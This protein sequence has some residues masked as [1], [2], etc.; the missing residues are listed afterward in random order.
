MGQIIAQA[1]RRGS[2]RAAPT[3]ASSLPGP[4]YDTMTANSTY[5]VDPTSKSMIG[6]PLAAAILG[7]VAVSLVTVIRL[8]LGGVM[9]RRTADGNHPVPIERRIQVTVSSFPTSTTTS[10]ESFAA[11]SVCPT[12]GRS[13]PA[14]HEVGAEVQIDEPR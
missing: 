6:L 11:A 14:T 7:A 9:R 1:S 12:A 2:N 3:A 4:S 8:G 10:N 5:A 13:C